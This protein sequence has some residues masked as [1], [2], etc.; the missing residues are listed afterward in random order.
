[1]CLNSDGVVN[2]GFIAKCEAFFV[3]GKD[4]FGGFHK[5]NNVCNSLPIEFW[6]ILRGLDLAWNRGFKNL[7]VEVDNIFVI[8]ALQSPS[9][10]NKQGSTL[11]RHILLLLH[12][13]EEV[14]FKHIFRESNQCADFLAKL[15]L[16]NN[17]D[18][19]WFDSCLLGLRRLISSDWSDLSVRLVA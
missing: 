16:H 11:V 2:N 17:D 19:V 14:Q 8:E 7:M 9:L 1:M 10:K 12:H 6:G 5:S 3:T 13:F 15:I 18:C 4:W